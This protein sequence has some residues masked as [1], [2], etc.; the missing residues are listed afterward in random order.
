LVQVAAGYRQLYEV[1]AWERAQSVTSIGQSGH[2]LSKQYDD[3]IIL[4]REGVYH[5]MPWSKEA[6][7]Q[8]TVY[9]LELRPKGWV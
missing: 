1:G 6:V 4:W 5:T 9:L 3:Q 2:P 7:E 8:A